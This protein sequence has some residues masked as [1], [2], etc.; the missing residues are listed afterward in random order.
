MSKGYSSILNDAYTNFQRDTLKVVEFLKPKLTII[1][2][3]EET[4]GLSYED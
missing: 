4:D 3:I 1:T 2:H